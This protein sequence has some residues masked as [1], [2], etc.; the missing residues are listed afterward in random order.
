M[1]TASLPL[2]AAQ[3]GQIIV[4]ES[5]IDGF[6]VILRHLPNHFPHSAE[7]IKGEYHADMALTIIDGHLTDYD[8]AFF[9]PLSL[10]KAL[11]A[12]GIIVPLDCIR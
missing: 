6:T 7:L 5:V 1:K 9:A 8:G 11:N 3:R 4:S 10:V 2:T 12:K